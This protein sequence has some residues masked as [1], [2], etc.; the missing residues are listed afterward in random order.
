MGGRGYQDWGLP[1][2]L[3]STHPLHIN[4]LP[5]LWKKKK[6]IEFNY[7]CTMKKRKQ[8]SFATYCKFALL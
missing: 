7:I 4:I 3:A 8:T 1:P 6:M 5:F 2:L